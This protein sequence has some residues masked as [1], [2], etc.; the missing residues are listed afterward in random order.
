MNLAAWHRF[1]EKVRLAREASQESHFERGTSGLEVEFNVLD[2]AFRPVRRVGSGPESRSFADVLA[3]ERIPEWAR[4]RA[5]REVFDWMAE[6]AT[7]PYYSPLG[8]AWE[9]RLLE[10]LL[11]DVLADAGLS[12]GERF[13]LLH[14]NIPWPLAV[15]ER[16]I[17]DG[18]SLAK[19]RY[20]AR[21]VR[22][23][24]S[25]LA[26]AGIHTNHSL[27]EALL[28]WDFFHLPRDEREGSSLEA[29]R[30]ETMI[31]ATRLMR[32][33]CPLFIAVSASTP[34]AWETV[35]GEP[36]VVLT[37]SDSNR[38]LTFPNPESLDVGG[39]YASHGDYLRI[40]NGLVRSGVR[41][42]AN[43]W[44]PV[45]ARSDVDPV[46]RILSLTSEQL[47]E[48]Y[49]R[50]IYTTDEHSTHEAAEQALIV[51]N[52]CALV[53]IPLTRVEVRT[54]EGGDDLPLSVAKVAFKELLMFASYADRETGAEYRYDA[55]DVARARRN[56]A[57]AA[58]AGLD[59]EVEHPFSGARVLAREWLGA[60]LEGLRPLAGA[61]GSEELLAPLAEMAAGAPNPAARVRRWFRERLAGARRAPSSHEVVPPELFREWLEARERAVAAEA[62]EVAARWRELGDESGKLAE[63]VAPFEALGAANPALPVRLSKPPGEER[64]AAVGG[65]TG[66]VVE[67]SA[68]LI[69][70]PSVTNCP[71]ERLDEVFRC[72][73]FLAGVLR[74][75]GAEVRLWDGGRYPAL[76]AGFPGALLAPVTLGGHF[77][78]VEPEPNDSQ[79]E[80]C[81]EGD[82]LWGRGSA[83]MKTVVGSFLVWMRRRIAAGP[84]Y[85]G[86][87]LL[88]VGNEENGEGEPYGTPHLL[89]E[90]ARERSWAPELMILGERTGERGDERIGQVCTANR[91]V[92]R[93][94]LVAR[95]ER[96][97]TGMA[98]AP[99]DLLTRLVEV[100]ASL[101]E[102]LPRHLTLDGAGGW[103]TT[104]AFPFLNVGENGVYNISAG[105]G[106]LGL[107]VRPIPE[108]DVEALLGAVRATCQKLGVELEPEVLEGGVA[109]PPGNPHLGRLLAAV[110]RVSGRP[111]EI[112]RKLAGTSARFAP[113]GNAVVWGQSGVGPHTRNE[114]HFIP[115]IAPYLQVLDAF[116]ALE[117]T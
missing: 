39:L 19:R 2:R 81:V 117:E 95:G 105:E 53:D 71:R 80:P 1:A 58:R 98:G 57:A 22:L 20:L 85:P 109:C 37:E 82:Y 76:V 6:V 96:A 60:V 10:G 33:Y 4:S 46:N 108:D 13:Y 77:D 32:P 18:W 91:G 88:L 110:E 68:A 36:S 65:V 56:E 25:S 9:A 103:R 31:R 79:L 72:A 59:A 50:G 12:Y 92:V 73:R 21:C 116:A 63:L 27:P 97:H 66:E 41:F 64:I 74:G 29:F 75:A 38:L 3:E 40:S 84:P 17:P 106:A 78:V 11:L 30:S 42:G 86:V 61:L 102:L 51:E 104:T 101:A 90:L 70:I 34:L 55:T 94:R 28:S 14:G 26:T 115:S 112:G 83:D 67:L 15:D 93:L 23:F 52:I 62:A 113:G 99:A 69:R 43:N 5:Q 87:N 100:R 8:A 49:R 54:D 48:L 47:R 114:R 7:R 16:T 24:G 44:T 89:R 35:D 107:E 111:P 45:R